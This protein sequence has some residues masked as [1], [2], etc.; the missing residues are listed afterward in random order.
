[1]SASIDLDRPRYDGKKVDENFTRSPLNS[2]LWRTRGC[3]ISHWLA[4]MT[5]SPEGMALLRITCLRPS[6][7]TLK[8]CISRNECTSS[9]RALLEATFE[10]P[11]RTIRSKRRAS[12]VAPN[13]KTL[14]STTGSKPLNVVPSFLAHSQ[15]LRWWTREI[16]PVTPVG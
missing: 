10:H 16:K 8:E 5:T 1:M 2:D 6:S 7:S 3:W 13:C 15:R 14:D 12:M 9:S 4:P 11:L